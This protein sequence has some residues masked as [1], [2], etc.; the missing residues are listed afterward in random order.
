MQ[1]IFLS[2]LLITIAFS[3]ERFLYISGYK[4]HLTQSCVSLGLQNGSLEYHV[5]LQNIYPETIWEN[6][7]V[8]KLFF[9]FT[10]WGKTYNLYVQQTTI[11]RIDAPRSLW[12]FPC[13]DFYFFLWSLL[14]GPRHIFKETAKVN[15]TVSN[16]VLFQMM[17]VSCM[18]MWMLI[19]LWTSLHFPVRLAE[20]REEMFSV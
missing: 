3:E 1:K 6:P 18:L 17:C 9:F 20:R 13:G 15:F 8:Y 4:P 10:V 7:D 12:T 2:V 14:H 19:S 5:K 16:V 11:W